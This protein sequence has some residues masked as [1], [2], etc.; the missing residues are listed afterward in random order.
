[1]DWKKFADQINAKYED[2]SDGFIGGD[3]IL[4]SIN[5]DDRNEKIRIEKKQEEA[6]KH[7]VILIL[8]NSTLDFP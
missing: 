8:K 2:R 5:K 6:M 4:A 7:Q 3:V 1:M